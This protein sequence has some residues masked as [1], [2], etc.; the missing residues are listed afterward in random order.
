MRVPILARPE[1][2]AQPLHCKP[3][4]SAVSGCVCADLRL[5]RFVEVFFVGGRTEKCWFSGGFVVERMWRGFGCR[6]GF[7]GVVF[8]M[9]FRI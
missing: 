3:F 2:R 7:A 1:G 5:I 9:D 4:C 6:S 8:G